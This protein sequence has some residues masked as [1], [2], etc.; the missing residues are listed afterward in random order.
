VDVCDEERGA[1]DTTGTHAGLA[2]GHVGVDCVCADQ[3]AGPPWVAGK[4]TRQESKRLIQ[5]L[6]SS[7]DGHIPFF[8]SDELPHDADALLEVYGQTVVPPRTGKPG[9]PRASDKVPPDDWLYAVVCKRRERGRV[10]EVTTHVVYGTP[11]RITQALADSPVLSVISTFGV[12]R[13]HLTI[14]QHARRLGRKVNA[15]SKDHAYLEDQWAL[16]FAYYHFVV[17]HLGLRHRLAPPLPTKGSGSPK[18][19]LQRTPAMAAGLTDHIWTMDELLSFRVPPRFVWSSMPNRQHY[20][21][22]H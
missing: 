3:Q 22:P 1:T 8:T 11:E 20:G 7:T 12:E 13:N 18:R 2:W 16:S 9:R 4:R 5:R 17:P 15:F 10:V 6:Q 19:W 14:R 21:V